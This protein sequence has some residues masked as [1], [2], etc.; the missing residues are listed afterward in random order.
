MDLFALVPGLR[1]ADMDQF[2]CGIAGTYGM[3]KEKYPIAA[4]VGAPLFDRIKATGA[5]EAAC[6][7]ET[8]RWHIEKAT[9]T[10]T[11]HPIEIL[12]Q[13]YRA[14]DAAGESG[15]APGAPAGT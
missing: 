2:C 12:L 7:S 9:G 14:A 15:P 6:D 3:K 10:R 11:R 4:A 13:A 8:C 5:S 1:A